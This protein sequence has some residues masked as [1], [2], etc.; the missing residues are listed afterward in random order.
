M[1]RYAEL[2]SGAARVEP[3]RVAVALEPRG[4]AVVV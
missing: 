3:V 2:G 1:D 4:R